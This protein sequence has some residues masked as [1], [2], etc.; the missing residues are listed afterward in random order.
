MSKARILHEPGVMVHGLGM[1]N[2]LAGSFDDDGEANAYNTA[3]KED[4]IRHMNN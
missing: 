3:D 2:P 4:I 1:E